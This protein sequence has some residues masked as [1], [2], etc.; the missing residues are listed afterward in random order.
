MARV[1]EKTAG[2]QT[3]LGAIFLACIRKSRARNAFGDTAVIDM[4]GN[5]FSS[6][7]RRDG[8]HYPA[9]VV[10][11]VS[12]LQDNFSGLADFLKLSDEDR[13]AL[14]ER[15]RSWI[16]YDARQDPNLHFTVKDRGAF[17]PTMKGNWDVN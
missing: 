12:E 16:A 17:L 9:I 10:C 6:F 7:T 15:V 4:A 8:T 14:F 3:K 2:N 1:V 13:I 5:V 11:H